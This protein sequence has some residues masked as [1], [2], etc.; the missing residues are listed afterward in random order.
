MRFV[1]DIAVQVEGS[2]PVLLFMHGIGGNSRN[3]SPQIEYFSDGYTA[4][5]WDARGY[6]ETG[7][8][9]GRFEQFADDAAAAAFRARHGLPDLNTHAA[10]MQ[11]ACG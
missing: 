6:G 3:W 4:A 11:A 9:V 1:G 5:A 8:A 2:G 7:G 10:G